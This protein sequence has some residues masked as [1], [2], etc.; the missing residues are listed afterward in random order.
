MLSTIK[1]YARNLTEGLVHR[2]RAVSYIPSRNP[3]ENL[4][5]HGRKWST[6]PKTALKILHS[7]KELEISGGFIS[8]ETAT[9]GWW[10]L[11]MSGC[12]RSVAP[13]GF[14]MSRACCHSRA[15]VDTN[16]KLSGVNTQ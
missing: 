10:L 15:F 3:S 12:H 8:K 7:F 1:Y 16:N 13:S 14:V 6:D 11:G 5:K 9:D 4:L 2:A